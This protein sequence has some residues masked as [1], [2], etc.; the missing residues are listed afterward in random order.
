MRAT[1]AYTEAGG[2]RHS[3]RVGSDHTGDAAQLACGPLSDDDTNFK[4]VQRRH[5]GLKR[6]VIDQRERGSACA[7]RLERYSYNAARSD[8]T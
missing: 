4:C 5:V 6:A 8:R 1:E 2:Q 3:E 7:G